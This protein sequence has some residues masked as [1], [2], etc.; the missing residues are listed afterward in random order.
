MKSQ[1]TVGRNQAIL[2]IDHFQPF[3]PATFIGYGW[4]IWKGPAD[5]TDLEG[6]EEQD[7]RSLALTEVD[8]S[9]VQLVHMLQGKE[10]CIKGEAKLER[11]RLDGRI[12]LDA[13][14]LQTL[15]E[16]SH[17]IPESWKEKTNGYTTYV[18]F[19]GTVL[20]GPSGRRYVLFLCW[21]DGRWYWHFSWLGDDFYAHCS[22]ALLAS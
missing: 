9:K 3:D 17:L 7:T 12:R 8:L 14:L 5:G 22:S 18:Y 6:E 11:S 2:S 16:H 1:A 21:R 4:S 20:R 13:R 10:L 15:W 19:D